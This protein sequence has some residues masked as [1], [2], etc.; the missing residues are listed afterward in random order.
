MYESAL[1]CL[2]I[3]HIPCRGGEPAHIILDSPGSNCN[4]IPAW[5]HRILRGLT[6]VMDVYA[7]YRQSQKPSTVPMLLGNKKRQD[8]DQ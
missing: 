4:H 8:D 3:V 5:I 7:G 1:Q 2:V 6:K